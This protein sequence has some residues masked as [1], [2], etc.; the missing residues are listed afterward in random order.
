MCSKGKKY[1]RPGRDSNAQPSVD[2]KD[3][4]LTRYH[5]ATGPELE[6]RQPALRN[7]PNSGYYSKSLYNNNTL[8]SLN[9][10]SAPF[11]PIRRGLRNSIVLTCLSSS[12]RLAGR[13]PVR[14]PESMK[15]DAA[16]EKVCH[17]LFICDP[18]TGSESQGMRRYPLPIGP[19]GLAVASEP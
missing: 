10:L 15:E 11:R 5:C 1:V 3:R 9:S 17:D 13:L 2:S 16:P 12:A 18:R 8:N 19:I 14:D 4:K 6:S 7:F